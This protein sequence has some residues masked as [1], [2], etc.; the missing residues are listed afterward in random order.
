MI[1]N[2]QIKAKN[3]NSLQNGE[4]FFFIFI[5]SIISIIFSNFLKVTGIG[6]TRYS[7]IG[8]RE[9]GSRY[10]RLQLQD[11]ALKAAEL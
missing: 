11:T 1:E 5:K 2:R 4:I 10:Y 7:V 9:T 3:L 6:D 8:Y